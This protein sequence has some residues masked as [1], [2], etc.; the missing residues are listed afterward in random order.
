[1]RRSTVA[2][3]GFLVIFCF[4]KWARLYTLNY[5]F[6]DMYA[7]LQM[8]VSWMDDR[9]FMYD[10]IWSYHHRIHNYYTVFFWAPFIRLGGA[11]GLFVSQVLLLML[12]FGLLNERL[13]RQVPPAFPAWVRFG[14]VVS[15]LLGPVS[16]WL[17]DHPNIGWHTE[18]SYLPFSLLFA[19]ALSSNS[20]VWPWV[21]GALVV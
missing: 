8:A 11:Y 6:N 20:R 4:F 5:S 14:F 10:N 21:T 16:L 17:N 13:S 9:P 15:I 7:F 2:I 1:M 19:L 18:L 3:L 12:A